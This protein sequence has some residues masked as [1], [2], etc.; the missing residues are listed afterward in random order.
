MALLSGGRIG[1]VDG[2]DLGRDPAQT[3]GEALAALVER[4]RCRLPG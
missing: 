2:D 1:Q 4:L 3:V